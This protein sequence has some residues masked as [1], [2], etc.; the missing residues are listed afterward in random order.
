MKNKSSDYWCKF[1]IIQEFAVI[2]MEISS[3]WWFFVT[4]TTISYFWQLPMPMMTFLQNDNTSVSVIFVSKNSYKT[5]TCTRAMLMHDHYGC[6]GS[7]YEPISVSLLLLGWTTSTGH[8]CLREAGLQQG[9]I[10]QKVRA[11]TPNLTKICVAITW[12][13]MIR[14]GHNFAYAMTAQLSWHVQ[15]CG[16]IYLL[17]IIKARRTFNRFQL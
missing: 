10:S 13:M 6:K 14:S 11:H 3:I 2:K 15:I 16:L 9:M 7:S 1:A 4:G 12:K 17:V 5:R 8:C